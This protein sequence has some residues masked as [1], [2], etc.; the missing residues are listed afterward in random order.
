MS[1]KTAVVGCEHW[2]KNLARNFAEL[3]ALAAIID[4]NPKTA[5][6]MQRCTAWLP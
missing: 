3:G 6:V 5:A 4:S 1:I 2:A